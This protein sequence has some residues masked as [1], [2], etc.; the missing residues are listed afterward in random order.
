M[1]IVQVRTKP[2]ERP[3][4]RRLCENKD[5]TDIFN[6]QSKK[7]FLNYAIRLFKTDENIIFSIRSINISKSENLVDLIDEHQ[8]DIS[9]NQNQFQ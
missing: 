1:S 2:N 4:K 8:C 3:T 5:V 7:G 9:F 6:N